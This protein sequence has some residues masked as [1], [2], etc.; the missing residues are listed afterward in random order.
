MT[1]AERDAELAAA[2]HAASHLPGPAAAPAPAPPKSPA[3]SAYDK[4]IAY[5]RNFEAQLN[6]SE[7]IA[8]GFT[9]NEVGVLQIEGIGFFAPDILT[10]YGRD[11]MGMKTQLIQHVGQLS[12]TLRAVAKARADDAPRRI[13]FHLQVGWQG[14]ESGDSSA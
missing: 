14:G 8:F 1:K 7:E 9:G 6:A 2:V 13:G 11:E 3:E 12:V 10:F 5:I 4:L